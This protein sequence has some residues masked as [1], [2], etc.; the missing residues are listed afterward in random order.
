MTVHKKWKATKIQEVYDGSPY[1]TVELHQVQLPDGTI[2]KDYHRIKAGSFASIVPVTKERDFYFLRQYRY[3]AD[4]V[5]LALP[6]GRVEENEA[7]ELAAAR[8]LKEETGLVAQELEPLGEYVTSCT[9]YLSQSVF[10]LGQ[11]TKLARNHDPSTNDDIETSE[12]VKMDKEQVLSAIKE[13]QFVSLGHLTGVMLA[14]RY[15]DL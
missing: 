3:G 15:L 9:Y 5:G 2:A 14:L 12:L 7:M 10:F 8:E 11:N 1:L 13:N 6:G 4:R